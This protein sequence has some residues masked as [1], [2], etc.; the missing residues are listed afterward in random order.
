MPFGKLAVEPEDLAYLTAAFDAAWAEIE[1]VE[2]IDPLA[3]SAARER[4]GFIFIQ[5]WRA[6]PDAPLV[7]QAVKAFRA[8]DASP[9]RQD[10]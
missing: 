4:L 3:R 10:A 2:P 5:I 6:D 1:R 7:E 8:G 9:V